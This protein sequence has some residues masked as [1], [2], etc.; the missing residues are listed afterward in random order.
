MDVVFGVH[1]QSDEWCGV[2]LLGHSVAVQ[3]YTITSLYQQICA[4]T[5]PFHLATHEN[6]LLVLHSTPQR[7]QSFRLLLPRAR[8]TTRSSPMY[9][10]HAFKQVHRYS[11]THT[12]TH[13]C[14]Q[15]S[16]EYEVSL[17]CIVGRTKTTSLFEVPYI[18]PATQYVTGLH[19]SSCY[20]HHLC[21][22]ACFGA[23]PT[24]EIAAVVSRTYLH[25][26]MPANGVVFSVDPAFNITSVDDLT[27]KCTSF[28]ADLPAVAKLVVK[29][30]EPKVGVNVNVNVNVC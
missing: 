5:Q 28:R 22:H 9:A 30:T 20:Y 29:W 2:K 15:V 27:N 17:Q 7:K 12:H 25:L 13:A 14:T 8:T 1:V 23:N 21:W 6:S 16:G 11:R 4:S 26:S 10:L 19:P 18:H 3:S 24:N